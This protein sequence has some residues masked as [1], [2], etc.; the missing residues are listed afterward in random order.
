MSLR[1]RLWAAKRSP[2]LG[3]AE[4]ITTQWLLVA[5]PDG[6][7][8]KYWPSLR[9]YLS[10]LEGPQKRRHDRPTLLYRGVLALGKWRDHPSARKGLMHILLGYWRVRLDDPL[11]SIAGSLLVVSGWPHHRVLRTWR[12]PNLKACT[13]GRSIPASREAGVEA[14]RETGAS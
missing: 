2:P 7:P 1:Y 6:F 3:G 13:H 5:R 8:G 12:R 4:D 11:P 9:L 10:I 14:W